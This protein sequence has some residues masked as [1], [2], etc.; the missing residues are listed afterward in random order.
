[1][2][3][4]DLTGFTRLGEALPLEELECAEKPGMR[5]NTETSPFVVDFEGV[6]ASTLGIGEGIANAGTDQANSGTAVVQ[7]ADWHGHGYGHD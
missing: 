7:P 5:G 4:A 1:V 3:F 6:G 2:A